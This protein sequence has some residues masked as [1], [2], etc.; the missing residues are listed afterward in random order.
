MHVGDTAPGSRKTWIADLYL[1]A[2]TIVEAGHKTPAA[3]DSPSA[4][5]DTKHYLEDFERLQKT[6]TSERDL[7]DRMTAL[8]RIGL[9]ISCG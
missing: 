3:P 5:Q 4:I 6:A 2:A 8:T 9:R 1:V 7:F